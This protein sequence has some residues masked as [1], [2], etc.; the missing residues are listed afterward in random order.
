MLFQSFKQTVMQAIDFSK[1]QIEIEQNEENWNSVRV[2]NQ[3]VSEDSEVN[4][5]SGT[6]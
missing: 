6:S 2:D 4:T 5:E 3:D 1:S